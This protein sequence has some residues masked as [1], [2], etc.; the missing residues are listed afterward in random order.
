MHQMDIILLTHSGRVLFVRLQMAPMEKG[1]V[2]I[3][4]RRVQC[5]PP[6]GITIVVD[7]N[8]GAGGT[9]RLT[10]QVGSPRP[11]TLISSTWECPEAKG[12]DLKVLGG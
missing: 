2:K 3:Q 5:T 11:Q 10:V 9:L 7:R 6:T 8:A 12:L 1:R 4:Y